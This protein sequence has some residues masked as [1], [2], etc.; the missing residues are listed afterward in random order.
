M[1]QKPWKYYQEWNNA[2]FLHWRIDLKEIR[3]IV[4]DQLEIDTC[5]GEAWV[6]VVAFTMNKVRLR[7]LPAVSLISDFDELNIRTYVKVND[8]P[9]VYFL[10]LEAGKKVSTIVSKL[11]SGFPYRYSPIIRNEETYQVGEPDSNNYFRISYSTNN[12]ESQKTE[13]DLWLTERYIAYNVRNDRVEFYHIHH[14]EWPVQNVELNSFTMN[15]SGYP[16]C[17][18]NSQDLCHYSPR[19]QVVA[20]GRERVLKEVNK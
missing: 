18:K 12:Q 4:P 10:S 19:V 7:N 20:W 14:V 16:A 8:K 15:Y 13:L 5:N 1:P 17:L 11:A 9:G 6:S 3:S 2:V